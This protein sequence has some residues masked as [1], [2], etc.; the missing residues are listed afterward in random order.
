MYCKTSVPPVFSMITPFIVLGIEAMVRMNG[1]FGC[2]C[3]EIEDILDA[4]L[5]ARVEK[6][7]N[8]V[9]VM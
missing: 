6:A 8:W 7:V 1:L 5:S 2:R 9:L 4:V 3:D